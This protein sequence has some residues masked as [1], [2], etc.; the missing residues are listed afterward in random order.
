MPSTPPPYAV[1]LLAYGAPRS[2]DEVEPYL[3]DVRGGRPTPPEVV[4][5]LEARYAAI[6]GTSPLLD[7]TREQADALAR[8]LGGHTP[9]YVGM[10]HWHPYI[11][12]VLADAGRQGVR[13][14][15]AL[16]MAPHFSRM[17]IGAYQKK[18]DEALGSI[19]ATFVSQW[20]NH[21][22]FLDA[23]AAAV[24]AG[25][26]RFPAEAQ[27]TVPIVF[28]A[29]SLPERILV[30]GDPYA[31]QLH[32]SVAGVMA[33]LGDREHRFAFQSA[34]RTGEPWLGPDAG[35]VLDE[36]AAQGREHVLVC[37]IGFVA[38]HL[39]V[40]YDIDIELAGRAN[41]LGIRLERT[42][43]L[44]ADPSLIEALVDLV[45]SAARQRGWDH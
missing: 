26:G 32:A 28:T 1:L 29:H 37:P 11:K 30:D 2:L 20:H 42:P 9:V 4:K 15:V 8:A 24:R 36:L 34:A 31:G 14:V 35:V 27:P 17:S 5:D 10:R 33:R 3:L 45:R 25:L 16:A 18:V 44:N 41:R 21:P 12:D 43:S 22:R 38:D 6:G 7:R 13:R 39:E 40:L 19:E 23:V